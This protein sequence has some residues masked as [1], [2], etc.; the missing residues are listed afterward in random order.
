MEEGGHRS[1][2]GTE[3]G[4]LIST[5]SG[6][7]GPL[8]PRRW[9]TWLRSLHRIFTDFVNSRPEM[10]RYQKTPLIIKRH[11]GHWFLEQS[12]CQFPMTLRTPYRNISTETNIPAHL[13]PPSPLALYHRFPPMDTVR[14]TREVF[15]FG[16][17]PLLLLG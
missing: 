4:F 6:Y 3:A 5:V 15:P 8:F 13:E 1:A 14:I 10:G 11:W 2:Q 7:P 16:F 17:W 9:K 12:S